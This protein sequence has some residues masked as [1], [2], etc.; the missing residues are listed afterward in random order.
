MTNT[1]LFGSFKFGSF[2]FVWD[3]EFGISDFSTFYRGATG[4]R[5]YTCHLIPF[6]Y[7]AAKWRASAGQGGNVRNASGTSRGW[8]TARQISR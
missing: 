2:E 6:T 4:C 1:L 3:F 7:I 8:V 5:P